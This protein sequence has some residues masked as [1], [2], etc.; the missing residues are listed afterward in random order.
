MESIERNL[1]EICHRK[2]L[3][4]TDVA[5]WIGTS[6][7]NLLSS[8]KGNPTIS[9]LQDI[10]NALQ[11]SVSELLTKRPEKSLGMMYLDGQVYQVTLPADSM[12]QIPRYNRYDEMRAAVKD[13]TKKAIISEFDSSIMGMLEHFEIFSLFYDKHQESFSLSICYGKGKTLSF[14]YDKMEFADWKMMDTE[15][16]AKWDLADVTQEII[17]DIEGSVPTNLQRE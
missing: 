3:S 12:V 14:S 11:I 8:V 4:L 5:N 13:F 9:K 10:A 17:N 16:T 6:P 2:G 1:K 15:E 7:S